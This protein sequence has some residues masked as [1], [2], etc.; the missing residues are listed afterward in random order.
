MKNFF[1]WALSTMLVL[2]TMAFSTPQDPAKSQTEPAANSEKQANVSGKWSGAF[3]FKN[4]NDE[5]KSEPVYMILKQDGSTLTGSGGPNEDKQH[6]IKNGKV[7]GNKLTF[8]VEGKMTISFNL[9]AKGD[10]ITGDMNAEENGIKRT[11]KLSLKR[12][13]EK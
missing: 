3:E 4:D 2:G 12:V 6:P 9:T 8:E 7:D 1:V 5:T 13:S 11:A 10:Q